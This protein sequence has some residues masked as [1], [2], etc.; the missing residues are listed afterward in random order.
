M[1]NAL[2]KMIKIYKLKLFILI[3][4]E[5]KYIFFLRYK[6]NSININNHSSYTDNIPTPYFFLEKIFNF[7]RNKKINKIVDIGCGSGRVIYF[8]SRKNPAYKI[9]GYE[10]N[11]KIYLKSKSFFK[12]KKKI[13]ILNLNLLKKNKIDNADIFYLADPFKKKSDY[14]KIINLITKSKSKTYII[15]VNINKNITLLKKF[16]IINQFKFNKLGYKI[17]SNKI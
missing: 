13:N 4:Y 12:N 16:R 17:Y 1:L 9:L 10:I 5:I 11:K 6:G 2:I 3:Y 7:I 8:F 14:N 15:L